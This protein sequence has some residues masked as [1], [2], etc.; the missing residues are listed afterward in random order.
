LT[1]TSRTIDERTPPEPDLRSAFGSRA[2]DAE[3]REAW[4]AATDGSLPPDTRK[5]NRKRIPADKS[6]PFDVTVEGLRF[7]AYPAENRCDRVLVGRAALP[8]KREHELLAPFLR[9][10]AV[11]VDIGA[12]IGTYALWAA[13]LVGP[14]G[15]VIALEPHPRTFAKLEFNRAANDAQNVRC[16]NIA[17]GPESEMATLRFDG[18]GNVGGASLLL[19]EA[20][21]GEADERVSVQPLADILSEQ[22]V[23]RNDAIKVDVEGYEDRALLPYFDRAP[24]TGWPKTIMIETVLKDRWERDCLAELAGRGYQRAAATSENVILRLAP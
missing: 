24:R 9:E 1:A 11:F 17:A 13:R 19:D 15:L 6:G 10:G 22:N 18:G 8:E 16:L 4:R 14:A 20:M 2:P 12:N 7:R 23:H 3:A 5:A 21:G